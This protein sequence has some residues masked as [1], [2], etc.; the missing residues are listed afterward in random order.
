MNT[1]ELKMLIQKILEEMEVNGYKLETINAEKC[2]FNSL[3]KFCKNNKIE[4]YDI[5]VEILRFIVFSARLLFIR[6]NL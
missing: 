2:T 1:D 3:L 5:N 6:Y 4:K